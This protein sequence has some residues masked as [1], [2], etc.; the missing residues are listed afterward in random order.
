MAICHNGP[1]VYRQTNMSLMELGWGD[2]IPYAR[3]KYGFDTIC[4][5]WFTDGP[6]VDM[7]RNQAIKAALKGLKD[8]PKG[9]EIP[10]THI[11]FLDADMVWP[12]TVISDLL[13]HHD[14]GIVAGLYTIKGP[15]YTPVHLKDQIESPGDGPVLFNRVLEFDT[16][17]VPCD[18]VGMGC[19]IIPVELC[20]AMGTGKWFEYRDDAHGMP[21]VSEDVPFCLK[22]KALGAKIAFDPMIRC[23]HVTNALIDHRYH[24]RYQASVKHSETIGAT[25][26]IKQPEAV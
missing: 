24:H 8:E 12:T 21:R 1:V 13:A 23:G 26:S 4:L 15:P 14:D 3:E 19:T 22:A 7:L 2:R 5:R 17:L 18:V 10:F 20:K 16:E 25:V 9:K 6:R 11:V